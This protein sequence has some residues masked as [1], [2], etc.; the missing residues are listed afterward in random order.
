MFSGNA[1]DGDETVERRDGKKEKDKGYV[2]F[3]S[4]DEDGGVQGDDEAMTSFVAPSGPRFVSSFDLLSFITVV[5][6]VYFYYQLLLD[7]STVF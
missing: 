1:P 6:L 7:V 3:Y 4:D 2:A 5:F